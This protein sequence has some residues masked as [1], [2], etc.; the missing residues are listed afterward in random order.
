MNASIR[1]LCLSAALVLLPTTLMA[2]NSDRDAVDQVM[3]TMMRGFEAGDPT[4]ILQVL[5]KD[6]V[7]VGY[8]PVTKGM[9]QVSAEEWAKGF[10]GKPA[11]DEDKR[12]RKYEILD[13]T[14]HGALVKVSL[15]YPR[16]DG[17]DYLGLAKIDGKWMII[18]KSWT[19]RSKPA[20]P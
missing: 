3:Q 4:L 1:S 17:V 11:D 19:G 2:Q 20:A 9:M 5:R 8:S 15:D 10:P 7:V 16:W 13:V 6:G 14:E 18:S 12:H